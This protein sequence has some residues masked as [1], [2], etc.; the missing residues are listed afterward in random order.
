MDPSLTQETIFE[1]SQ[2]IVE[3]VSFQI[4]RYGWALYGFARGRLDP[5]L[6]YVLDSE[7]P[8][9]NKA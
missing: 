7:M 6:G 9:R 3:S 2:Q 8:P 5:G 1:T 4:D